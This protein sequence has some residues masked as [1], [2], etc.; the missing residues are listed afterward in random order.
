MRGTGHGMLYVVTGASGRWKPQCVLQVSGFCLICGET[1][2]AEHN[3]S[4]MICFVRQK[5]EGSDTYFTVSRFYSCI[6]YR[7]DSSDRRTSCMKTVNL[8]GWK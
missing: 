3:N 4:Q 7:N 2:T 6:G 8:N 5:K 1:H